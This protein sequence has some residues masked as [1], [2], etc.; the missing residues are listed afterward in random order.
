MRKNKGKNELIILNGTN[1]KQEIPI[2]QYQNMLEGLSSGHEIKSGKRI[3][4][5][6]DIVLTA[7]ESLIIEL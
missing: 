2:H 7:R 4:L 5:T 1:D 3:D 6:K